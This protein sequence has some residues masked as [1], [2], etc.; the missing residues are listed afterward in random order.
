MFN[1]NPDLFSI[2]NCCQWICSYT[3]LCYFKGTNFFLEIFNFFINLDYYYFIHYDQWHVC[4]KTILLIKI[5]YKRCIS[6]TMKDFKSAVESC[7]IGWILAAS[8]ES[9]LW[10]YNSLRNSS[11]KRGK[12]PQSEECPNIYMGVYV[13]VYL[14]LCKLF[15]G[16][17]F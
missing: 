12:L 4:T 14:Y 2:K 5:L 8:K 9:S 3:F 17:S 10:Q 1:F 15:W 11:K 16:R 7:L 13:C 6:W